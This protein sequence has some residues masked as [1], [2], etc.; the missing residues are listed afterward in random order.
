MSIAFAENSAIVINHTPVY[1]LNGAFTIEWFQYY[2]ANSSQI[3][4]VF[5]KG[6]LG[7]EFENDTTR[8]LLP[9]QTI[10]AAYPKSNYVEQWR[11]IVITRNTSGIVSLLIDGT[12][13][14]ELTNAGK[15]NN[16]ENIVLGRVLNNANTAFS[17]LLTNFRYTPTAYI[18]TQY[19]KPMFP[20]VPTDNTEILLLSHSAANVYTNYVSKQM[21]LYPLNTTHSTDSPFVSNGLALYPSTL[22]VDLSPIQNIYNPTNPTTEETTTITDG[23]YVF[24][25]DLSNVLFNDPSNNHLDYS[26]GITFAGWVRPT[27]TP[28]LISTIIINRTEEVSGQHTIGL[29][30]RSDNSLRFRRRGT[31]FNTNTNLSVVP[32]EWNFV[33]FSVS[34]EVINI[35]ISN[36]SQTESHTLTDP[37]PAPIDITNIMIG[38]DLVSSSTNRFM[39]GELSQLLLFNTYMDAAAIN[40]IRYYTGITLN[41]YTPSILAEFPSIFAPFIVSARKNRLPYSNNTAMVSMNYASRRIEPDSNFLKYGASHSD[42]IR[43]LKIINHI[44]SKLL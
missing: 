31:F 44:N 1:A 11:H 23:V 4:R 7:F 43:K 33:A 21:T 9:R 16:T 12:P 29:E 37:D 24:D 3:Q 38:G 40:T 35:Y 26:N 14:I 41:Y 5:Y 19:T 42:R 36:S 30:Y 17:G 32:N 22:P 25:K 13:L 18:Y 10:S 20:L 34:N 27:G 6:S 8:L 28:N 2:T 15:F 39:N